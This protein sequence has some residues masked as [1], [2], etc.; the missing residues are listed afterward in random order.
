MNRLKWGG[1]LFFPTLIVTAVALSGC[2]VPPQASPTLAEARSGITPAEDTAARPGEIRAE[3]MQ[4]DP[5]KRLIHVTRIDNGARDAV[6]FEYD[7]TRLYYHGREYPI[8][9]LEMGDIIAY[10]VPPPGAGDFDVIRLQ[11]PAQGRVGST[12]ARGAAPMPRAEVIEGVVERIDY[13]RG[14]FELRPRSGRNIIVTI[15][16]NARATDVE[17]FRRLRRG[18]LVRLEGEI[19]RPDNVQLLAF[20]G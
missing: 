4:I 12:L 1:F 15:P 14:M 2:V 6:P 20:L 18:D 7:Y 9:S 3:V 8:A 10:Q 16:Y 17:S 11:M 19:V 5:V 13:E